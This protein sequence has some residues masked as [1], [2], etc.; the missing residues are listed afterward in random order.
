MN[1]DAFTVADIPAGAGANRWYK[2]PID[3]EPRPNVERWLER[4]KERPGF[5]A[6]VLDV[7]L[8]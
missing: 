6:H 8:S 1:G 5:R 3:R 7:P 4:L 2:L